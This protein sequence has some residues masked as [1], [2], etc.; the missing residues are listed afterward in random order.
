MI[1]TVATINLVEANLVPNLGLQVAK[2]NIVVG[3]ISH[4]RGV[5][6]GIAV[7]NLSVGTWV[8]GPTFVVMVISKF[9]VILGMEFLYNA[10][11]HVLSHL[12]SIWIEGMKKS[13]TVECEYL[14][15]IKIESSLQITH[16]GLDRGS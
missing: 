8:H 10:E 5:S 2:A 15:L 14:S 13:C 11:V 6:N 9:D 1:N 16:N 7:A 4:H 12:S 3:L